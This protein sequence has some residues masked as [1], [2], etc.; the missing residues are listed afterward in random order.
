[1]PLALAAAAQLS[2]ADPLS[3]RGCWLHVLAL[4]RA[5][6]TSDSLDAY[7]RHAPVLD[8]ELGLQP[9]VELRE[10]QTAI[11][12]QAPELA[13]W[14]PTTMV[15]WCGSVVRT[16]R[17]RRR[18]GRCGRGVAGDAAR[19]PGH[20]EIPS[21]CRY[22]A[23]DGEL[24]RFAGPLLEEL[25]PFGDRIAVIGQVGVVG[26]V[27]LATAWLRVLVADHER[28]LVDLARARAIGAR[29][30]ASPRSSVVRWRPMSPSKLLASACAGSKPPLANSA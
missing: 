16:S 20:G 1:M 22:L 6:R 9:G 12:R 28:A 7:T 3:D 27:A 23:A 8:D 29:T 15:V 21:V 26:P 25:G 10:L 18:G 17:R 2:A 19:R 13:A 30:A 4:Y 24:A 14:P 5:G 11:L